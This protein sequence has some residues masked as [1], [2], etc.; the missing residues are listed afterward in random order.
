MKLRGESVWAKITDGGELVKDAGGR[1]EIFYKLGGKSY[2]AG[3]ANLEPALI[4]ETK[5]DSE[6]AGAE[7]AAPSPTSKVTATPATPDEIIAYTDGACTGNP[8]PMGIG[9]VLLDQGA[10]REVGEYLG[11]GTN[12]IAELTAIWR[13]ITLTE[14]TRPIRIHTDSSYAIGVLSKNWKA[15]ANQQLIADIKAAMRARP[16]VTL[17]KVAGHSGVPENE[18][19]D[20]LARGAITS[21]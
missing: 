4:T 2:R 8:G 21:R 5:P 1:V 7:A 15:K 6:F 11:A 13:A 10:R 17:V 3:A 18:R 9:V 14:T 20:A 12:N 16:R 19:C